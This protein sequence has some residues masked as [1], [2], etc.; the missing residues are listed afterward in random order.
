MKE[1]RKETKMDNIKHFN[2]KNVSRLLMEEEKW[3]LKKKRKCN[4]SIRMLENRE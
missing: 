3:G 2:K 4:L 1:R